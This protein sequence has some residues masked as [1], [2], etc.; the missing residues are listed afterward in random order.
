MDKRTR[1]NINMLVQ[2]KSRADVQKEGVK[3]TTRIN[4]NMDVEMMVS[5]S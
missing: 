3:A 1:T 5:K 4:M 2:Q